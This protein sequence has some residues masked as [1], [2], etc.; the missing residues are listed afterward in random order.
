MMKTKQVS[1]MAGMM[2]GV[3]MVAGFVPGV[4]TGMVGQASAA[5]V[6]ELDD[7]AF[8]YRWD[9]DGANTTENYDRYNGTTGAQASDG[10]NEWSLTPTPTAG[11]ISLATNTS[12]SNLFW[13]SST[14]ASAMTNATGYTVEY[15]VRLTPNV[16]TG[17]D[18]GLTMDVADAQNLAAVTGQY[19]DLDTDN[20]LAI[21]W[22]LGAIGAVYATVAADEFFTV[23]I[24]A[25]PDVGAV[26]GLSY[27]LYINDLEVGDDLDRERPFATRR[28]LIGDV[29]GGSRGTTEIDYVAI[30]SGAF[31][32]ASVPE[33]GS[34]ALASIGA[35][36][37]LRRRKTQSV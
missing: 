14:A 3:G 28:M 12:E 37:F 8:T 26:G 13:V 6:A 25:T 7:L 2:F 20:D 18:G 33:P 34:L 21:Y 5:P 10:T 1:I 22:D 17:N 35:L 16:T 23:R 31:A 9:F 24:A 36:C 15:R 19:V 30:T 29:G 4:F 27:T 32:P 11:E